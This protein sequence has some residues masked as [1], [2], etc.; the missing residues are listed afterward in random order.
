M[1]AR[2]V[3]AAVLGLCA[4]GGSGPARA[5]SNFSAPAVGTGKAF[6]ADSFRK[7]DVFAATEILAATACSG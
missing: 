3:F 4:I 5:D 7:T 2:V 6:S 1:H